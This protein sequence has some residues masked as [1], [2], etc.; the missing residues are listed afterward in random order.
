M[1]TVMSGHIEVDENHVARIAG[2]RI[3]VIHLVM[4]KIANGWGPDEMQQ[5]FPHLTLGQIHAALSYY[6]DHRAECDAQIES[7]ARLADEMRASNPE[8]PFLKRIRMEGKL[9]RANGPISE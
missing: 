3:K 2:S 5:N 8:G 9:P 1:T 4:E 6:Y 7:S